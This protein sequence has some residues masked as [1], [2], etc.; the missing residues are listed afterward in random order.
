MNRIFQLGVVG[1]PVA[2]SLSPQIHQLFAEQCA[3]AI[4]YPKYLQQT[5]TLAD[6]IQDFFQ[7]D[8]AC[9]L[10]ITLPFKQ[11]VMQ[12]CYQISERAQAAQAVNTLINTPDGV[13]GDNTDGIGLITDIQQLG[14]KLDNANVLMLGAGGAAR[15]IAAAL[16]EVA[17]VQIRLLNRTAA[18]V[19]PFQQDFPQL[20]WDDACTSP[21][22]IINTCSQGGEQLLDTHRIRLAQSKSYDISYGERAAVFLNYCQQQ[23][24]TAVADGLGMLVYQAAHAFN[25]WFGKM[26]DATS[27]LQQL[28]SG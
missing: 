12:L 16:G 15:G 10:N 22:I 17:G 26:P 11:E 6:F 7:R 2:H 1:N 18:K 28:Q 8:T 25:L 20:S 9:G 5:D 4:D 21:D 24:A 13:V 19:K 27:V 23:K 14:W 3:I